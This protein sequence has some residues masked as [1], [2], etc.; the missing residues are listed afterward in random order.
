MGIIKKARKSLYAIIPLVLLPMTTGSSNRPD[1][2]AGKPAQVI[3]DPEFLKTI[4][5]RL[6]EYKP[7]E[8]KPLYERPKE[9]SQIARY[10]DLLYKKLP[11]N[12][13]ESILHRPYRK[14][15]MQG[16]ASE[17]RFLAIIGVES[18]GDPLAMNSIA[19]GWMGL[20]RP[21]WYEVET[22]DYNT[23][24]YHPEKNSEVGMKIYRRMFRNIVR[25]HPESSALD[26][27]TL[28]N[29]ASA[30]NN[31]G[32]TRLRE[33]NFDIESMPEETRNYVT[34][35]RLLEDRLNQRH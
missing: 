16:I 31:G 22:S 18:A 14:L 3:V 23:E 26:K 19:R 20:T 32:F 24:W 29:L 13:F 28:N 7:S 5:V 1:I 21:A 30:A 17:T 11:W 2:S 34:K 15:G 9:L 12:N 35:I 33:R 25:F 10:V 6:A 8:I 4:N 27:Y